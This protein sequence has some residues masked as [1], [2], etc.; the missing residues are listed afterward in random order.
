MTPDEVYQLLKLAEELLLTGKRLTECA[1]IAIV[2]DR[3]PIRPTA[4]T[5]TPWWASDHPDDLE[6]QYRTRA[7]SER[8]RR[9]PRPDLPGVEGAS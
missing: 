9:P 5:A 1:R 3:S 6:M 8:Y 4:P 2:T 7:K